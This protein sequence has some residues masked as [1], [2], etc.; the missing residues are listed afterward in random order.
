MKK[1]KKRRQQPGCKITETIDRIEK[2]VS[3][4]IRIYK[5]V[6]PIAKAILRNGRKTT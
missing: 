3:T 4:A 6:E 2:A 5:A 1:A